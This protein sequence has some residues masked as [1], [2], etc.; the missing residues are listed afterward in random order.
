MSTLKIEARK[1]MQKFMRKSLLFLFI[2][3]CFLKK[4]AININDKHCIITARL[5]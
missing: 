3:A 4:K 1:I 5:V 2:V